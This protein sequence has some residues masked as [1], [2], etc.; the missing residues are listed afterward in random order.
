V[1]GGTVREHRNVRVEIEDRVAIL[2]IDHPPVNAIDRATL[3]DLWAAFD[4]TLADKNVK[5]IVLTGAGQCFVAGAD[6]KAIAETADA[7]EVRRFIEAGHEFFLQIERSPKPVIAAINGRFCLGG[8]NELAMA[9]HIRIAEEKVKFGQPEIKLG[10]IPGWGA[11]QRLVRLVG[12]G[13][14]VEMIL[15]GDHVRAK[16]AHRLG[17]ANQIVPVGSALEAAKRMARRLCALSGVA[18]AKV[19]DAIYGGLDL[20]YDEG[21]AHEIAR[22]G[23][24]AETEDMREGVAAFLEKRKPTFRDR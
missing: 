15:T 5:A 19:L 4:Q 2:T 8:G 9:C 1:K 14:A 18:L 16:E 10:M 24:M 13:K 17:L 3:N 23:E 22:F 11:T 12:L 20:P 6:I 7:E 21:L